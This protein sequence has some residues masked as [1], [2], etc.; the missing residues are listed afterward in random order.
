MVDTTSRK[1]LVEDYLDSLN[2]TDEFK[3]YYLGRTIFVTGG[4]GAIG[5]NLAIALSLL[6]GS[7]GMIIILDNLSAIKGNKPW[8]LPSLENMLF[9]FGDVRSDIDL[10]RVFREKP[11]VVFHLASFF[12]NQN[13]VDY[14]ERS[15]D[16]DINGIIKLLDYSDSTGVE[17]FVFASSGCAIYGSYGEM[18]LKEDFISMHLTTPYQINKMTGEMY[19]NFYYHH[20]GLNIVNCRFFNSYGPGE[21]PG[22]Y[23]NVIPNFIFWAMN[24]HPLPITGTGE[25]TRDFTY[26]LDLVQGLVKAAYNRAAI[27]KAL[28]LASGTEVSIKDLALMVNEATNNKEPIKFS[29]RRRWDTK[30]RLMASIDLAAELI[31]YEPIV[32]FEEGLQN[33][34]DWFKD[35]WDRIRESADFPPG[36]SSAVRR[37]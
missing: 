29:Q 24:G 33:T 35:N 25:E 1:N 18:P 14:P 13:S 34:I 3:N 22:Q 17:R 37:E 23:R 28:N 6:V 31:G 10:K 5:S 32:K 12:A 8:N 16:V 27:G 2:L 11:S 9:V 26:V 7:E 19:C 21:V 30:K 20:Y 4:G 36:M 15:A